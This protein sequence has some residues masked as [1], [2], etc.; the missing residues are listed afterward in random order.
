MF[1]GLYIHVEFRKIKKKNMWGLGWLRNYGQNSLIT[2]NR[3]KLVNKQQRFTKRNFYSHQKSQSDFIGVKVMCCLMM[4]HCIAAKVESGFNRAVCTRTILVLMQHHWNE[5]L[6]SDG[7]G[8]KC[9]FPFAFT[10]SLH[11]ALKSIFSGL[12][13]V[14]QIWNLYGLKN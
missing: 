11:H 2:K 4:L 3:S 7:T 14:F 5:V 6:F 1:D 10:Q 8:L 12:W 9:L 13:A